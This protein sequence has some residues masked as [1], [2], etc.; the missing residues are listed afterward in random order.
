L[1]LVNPTDKSVNVGWLR[2]Y[3]MDAKSLMPAGNLNLVNESQLMGLV[4]FHF[5]IRHAA[6]ILRRCS[7][8]LRKLPLVASDIP[9]VFI[10]HLR[11]LTVKREM[12]AGHRGVIPRSLVGSKLAPGKLQVDAR[13]LRSGTRLGPG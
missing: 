7:G 6:S 4:E 12:V 13:S 5:G 10:G 1:L 9:I 3:E 11:A 8:V 2:G